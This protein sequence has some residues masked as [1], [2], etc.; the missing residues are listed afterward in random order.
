MPLEVTA[1]ALQAHLWSCPDPGFSLSPGLA[2]RALDFRSWQSP[3][4]LQ[5][6]PA[7]MPPMPQIRRAG[8]PATEERGRPPL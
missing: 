6:P 7:I 8:P 2:Y 1:V 3:S 4:D 5:L